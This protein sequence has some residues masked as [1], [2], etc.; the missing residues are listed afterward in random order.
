MQRIR[1]GEAEEGKKE[2]R[3]LICCSCDGSLLVFGCPLFSACS[4]AETVHAEI[5]VSRT[6]GKMSSQT[7][8]NGVIV[9]KSLLCER[10][11]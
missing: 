10:G 2:D 3:V 1:T 11:N 7:G 4:L 9:V 8:E 6:V 5:G